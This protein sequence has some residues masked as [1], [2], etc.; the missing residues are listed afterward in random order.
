ML[1]IQNVSPEKTVTIHYTCPNSKIIIGVD[2]KAYS[3]WALAETREG[4][5]Q[6]PERRGRADEVLG[7]LDPLQVRRHLEAGVLLTHC[8]TSYAAG[9]GGTL[10]RTRP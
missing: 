3:G 6:A 9:G 5:E 10:P 8:G 4:A 7:P 2:C 1:Q